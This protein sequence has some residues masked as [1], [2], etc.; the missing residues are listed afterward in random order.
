MSKIL[1]FIGI[2]IAAIA[3]GGL[4]GMLLWNALVPAIFGL[5][6]ISYLQSMGLIVLCRVFLMK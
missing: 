5:A 2:F 4:I 3:L 6:K 1:A